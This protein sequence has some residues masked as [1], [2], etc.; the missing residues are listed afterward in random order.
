[1]PLIPS[2]AAESAV[3]LAYLISSSVLS[4]STH[5]LG[6]LII[7]S[8]ISLIFS[9]KRYSED[10]ENIQRRLNWLK[11]YS[12][13]VTDGKIDFEFTPEKGIYCVAKKEI[14]AFFEK[15]KEE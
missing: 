9:K 1:M 11:S 12:E 13:E 7:L 3:S 14:L 4:L 15:K 10:P 6:K 2:R 5:T 8:L